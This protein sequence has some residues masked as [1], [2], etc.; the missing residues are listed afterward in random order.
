MLSNLKIWYFALILCGSVLFSSD[1]KA[2]HL[3]GGEITYTCSGN[4]SYQIKLRIYR[5]CNGGGASFDQSV[6]FT[7]FDDQGNV[8]FNPSVSKGATVQVPSATGNP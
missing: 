4:N 6:N 2:A 3:V 1:L 7:I 8:L 5:D